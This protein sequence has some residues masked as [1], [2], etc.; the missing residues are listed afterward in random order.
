MHYDH[1]VSSERDN[2]KTRYFCI[3]FRL[4]IFLGVV[5][6]VDISAKISIGL[7]QMQQDTLIRI[8]GLAQF[9]RLVILNGLSDMLQ[10]P[11]VLFSRAFNSV[12]FLPKELIKLKDLENSLSSNIATLSNDIVKQLSIKDARSI[13]VTLM[14]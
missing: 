5:A 4:L 14:S 8:S 2:K 1:G 3:V 12:L 11:R 6:N 10:Q 13:R 7:L 9:Y